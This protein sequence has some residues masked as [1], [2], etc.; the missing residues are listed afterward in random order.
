MQQDGWKGSPYVVTS[1]AFIVA[2][3]LWRELAGDGPTGLKILMGAILAG[4]VAGAFLISR[5]LSA[6]WDEVGEARFDNSRED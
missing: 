4:I 3:P 5:S 2:I 6:R 1:L